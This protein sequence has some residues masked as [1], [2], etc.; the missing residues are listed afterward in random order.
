MQTKP[1][2]VVGAT[3]YGQNGLETEDFEGAVAYK[4]ARSFFVR[5]LKAKL[6]VKGTI[7]K[8]DDNSRY[9]WRK[10]GPVCFRNYGKYL[11]TNQE[12]CY[13]L[14]DRNRND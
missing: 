13:N 4:T 5:E 8:R 12:Y 7:V 1:T 11:L 14:A 2:K 6:F 10:V 3:Y 9:I